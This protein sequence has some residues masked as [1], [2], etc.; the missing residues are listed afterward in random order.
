MIAYFKNG[1]VQSESFPDPQSFLTSCPYGI[2]TTARTVHSGQS[3]AHFEQHVDRLYHGTRAEDRGKL[4]RTE[5]R[6][7]MLHFI[8]SAVQFVGRPTCPSGEWRLTLVLCPSTTSTPDFLIYVSA[9]PFVSSEIL[10]CGIR[11]AV[12][13]GAPRRSPTCKDTKW[14]IDRLPLLR[15]V[16]ADD[17]LL[18]D[19]VGNVYEGATS[20]VYAVMV[21]QE[22]NQMFIVTPGEQVLP[23]VM[24]AV[25]LTAAEKLGIRV[26]FRFVS[27][28]DLLQSR[29]PLFVSSVMKPIVP[30]RQL[31][32]WSHP[33][34]LYDRDSVPEG[35]HQVIDLNTS[36]QFLSFL[37][38]LRN[39]VDELIEKTSV[40]L[41]VA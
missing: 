38:K 35:E 26:D 6:D 8:I 5:L 37:D 11:L 14:A 1:V 23:G 18:V 3:I 17:A 10:S 22:T 19:P 36:E 13:G 40:S 20:N 2:Y 31:V 39:K 29:I 12:C 34:M 15:A 27:T 21:D 32:F 9:L 28:N 30:I 4:T 33:A 16:A 24:R 25:I 41:A 7:Q